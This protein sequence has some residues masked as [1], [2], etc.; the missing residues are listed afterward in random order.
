MPLTTHTCFVVTCC[1][2]GTPLVVDDEYAPHYDSAAEAYSAA[3]DLGW[4]V[5]RPASLPPRG[6]RDARTT[7]ARRARIAAPGPAAHDVLR[8]PRPAQLSAHPARHP[9][10]A[11]PRR[12]PAAF[13]TRAHPAS[14]GRKRNHPPRRLRFSAL[15]F[16]SQR[17]ADVRLTHHH[18]P[19]LAVAPATA[20]L[21]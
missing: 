17:H 8:A 1:A 16:R 2:C 19:R 10:R 12:H 14:T 4:T 21:A 9:L 6:P 5:L 3:R 15:E 11:R 7:R 13:P 18:S 20:S